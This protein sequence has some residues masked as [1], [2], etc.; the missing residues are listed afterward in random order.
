MAEYTIDKIGFI[1]YNIR[2]V[3]VYLTTVVLTVQNWEL[4]KMGALPYKTNGSY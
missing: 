2:E 4:L 1:G 3:S